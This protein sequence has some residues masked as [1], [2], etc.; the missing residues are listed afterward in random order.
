M[1]AITKNKD[2]CVDVKEWLPSSKKQ[3]FLS[4]SSNQVCDFILKQ[5][6]TS[7]LN[8]FIFNQ[9]SG[10]LYCVVLMFY[11]AAILP[12]LA[13][14]RLQ[15]GGICEPKDWLH[16]PKNWFGGLKCNDVIVTPHKGV[17]YTYMCTLPQK[18]CSGEIGPKFLE[19]RNTVIGKINASK[20]ASRLLFQR[21]LL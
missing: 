8:V 9:T 17:L 2:I 7:M 11:F 6:M 16:N 21:A 19:Y 18:L 3:L 13:I 15:R 4:S 20:L 1:E 12:E 14:P 5:R 10:N